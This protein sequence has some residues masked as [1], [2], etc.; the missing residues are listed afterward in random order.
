MVGRGEGASSAGAGARVTRGAVSGKIG[1]GM[2]GRACLSTRARAALTRG[3]TAYTVGGS[4][5]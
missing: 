3:H 1:I 5:A 4:P 2:G